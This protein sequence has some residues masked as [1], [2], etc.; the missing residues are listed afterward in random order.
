MDFA[1]EG[2]EESAEERLPGFTFAWQNWGK[3]SAVFF[4]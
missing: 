1:R 4:G 3:G 2:M